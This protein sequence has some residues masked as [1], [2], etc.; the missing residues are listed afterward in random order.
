[1]S[2][3]RISFGTQYKF[4]LKLYE[5]ANDGM[6]IKWT[7]NG[8]AIT[9]EEREFEDNILQYYPGFV[10]VKSFQ[11]F[12]RLLRDYT[13]KFR[14]LRRRKPCGFM[15]EYRHPFFLRDRPDQ[16]LQI[17]KSKRRYF[18]HPLATSS[19]KNKMPQRLKPDKCDISLSFS[20]D[21]EEF[22][23]RT[24]LL[25]EHLVLENVSANRNVCPST[26]QAKFDKEIF[27]EKSSACIAEVLP[28]GSR[29]PLVLVRHQPTKTDTG[30]EK[31]T[32]KDLF[33]LAQIFAGNE[34]SETE[35][36]EVA[37]RRCG[38]QWRDKSWDA[39]M[40]LLTR[41]VDPGLSPLHHK[42]FYYELSIEEM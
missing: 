16:V 2:R 37:T 19:P 9:I 7:G 13:F 18:M 29:N 22:D 1:M 33:R 35:F 40:E 12:R 39:T 42:G 20:C 34:L 15:L 28:V 32:E 25:T 27:G 36:W 23:C 14:I 21:K 41:I 17:R 3:P 10:Q 6:I 11:N 26:A 8:T 5:I 4:P 38:E 31:L 24:Q 30:S